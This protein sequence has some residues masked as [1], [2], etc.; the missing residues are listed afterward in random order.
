[1]KIEEIKIDSI[2]PDTKQPRAEFKNIDLL[3]KS[4]KKEGLISPI[5]V[6]EVE[7]KYKII[8]GERR[9][10]ALILLKWKLIPCIIKNNTKDIYIR[11]LAT[12]FHKNPLN[13]MERAL[14]INKLIKQ[15]MTRKKISN[16][17]NVST[18]TISYY[19]N[20]SELS[21]ETK[22]L[23]KDENITISE[24]KEI[25]EMIH[26]IDDDNISYPDK[27]AIAVNSFFS[28]KGD[29]NNLLKKKKFTF[30]FYNYKNKM[31]ALNN[32]LTEMEDK[33][34]EIKSEA[35]HE[36]ISQLKNTMNDISVKAQRIIKKL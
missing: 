18:S 23:L 6:T 8:D 21:D 7:G 15:G 29:Y 1:M 20:I 22:K 10:R 3:S 14:S 32:V 26:K 25:T 9:F 28:K 24:A 5:E 31:F 13:Y 4:I 12:D 34:T 2:F 33:V 36:N 35:S 16:L 30:T 19:I 11:Q 17:L 27:E